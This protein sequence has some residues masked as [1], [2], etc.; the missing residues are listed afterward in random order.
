MLRLLIK[1]LLCQRQFAGHRIQVF[2]VCFL[3]PKLLLHYRPL[4]YFSPQVFF[5]L[6][7]SHIRSMPQIV[8]TA[9]F[10]FTNLASG[11]S[12]VVNLSQI[13]LWNFRHDVSLNLCSFWLFLFML[14]SILPNMKFYIFN[15]LN[16][17]NLQNVLHRLFL[18]MFLLCIFYSLW[19]TFFC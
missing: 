4:F 5:S 10:E 14:F 3:L 15:S 17:L 9:V 19:V 2:R 13:K 11:V 12:Y 7:S 8:S 18:R 16:V 6:L 1:I